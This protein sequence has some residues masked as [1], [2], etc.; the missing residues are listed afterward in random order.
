MSQFMPQQPIFNQQPPQY[1]WQVPRPYQY[2]YQPPQVPQTPQPSY[3]PSPE[4]SGFGGRYIS[5]VDE[6]RLD[7]VPMNGQPCLFPTKDMTSIYLK[8]W[9]QDGRLITAKYILDSEQT[10]QN[11][12]SQNDVQDIR[13][14][15]NRLESALAMRNQS[16]KKK[17]NA[18]EVGQ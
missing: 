5:S 8:V 7:E 3:T 14:R 2:Q 12:P 17:G 15:L 11:Q 16:G 9:N 13:E 10:P 6:V 18:N 1:N 4:L